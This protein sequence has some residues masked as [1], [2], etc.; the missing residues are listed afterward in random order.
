[1]G[2]H[3]AVVGYDGSSNADRA[4]ETAADLIGPDGTVHVVTGFQPESQAQLAQH[5]QHLPEEFRFAYDQDAVEKDRQQAALTRLRERGVECTGHV[6]PDDPATAIIDVAQ[7]E[8]ADLVVVGTR[9]LGA[10]RR[11]LRGSVSTRVASH[12]PVSV[13]IVHEPGA[14]PDD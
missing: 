7:R 10:V 5:L 12:A 13:L 8:G 9:G 14:A 1:M 3:T 2:Y 6:V 11:F 4:V